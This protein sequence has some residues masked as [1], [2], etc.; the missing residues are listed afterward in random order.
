MD[1]KPAARRHESDDRTNYLIEESYGN[2]FMHATMARSGSEFSVLTWKNPLSLGRVS[3]CVSNGPFA[4]QDVL[5]PA[6]A[7]MLA[8]ALT[9]AADD[10]DHA[11]EAAAHCDEVPA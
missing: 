8:Q 11:I 5:H 2:T 9:M 6:E 4:L 1:A 10:A 7:R 3:V